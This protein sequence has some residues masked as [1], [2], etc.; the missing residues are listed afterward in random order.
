VLFG[1][2]QDPKEP[3]NSPVKRIMKLLPADGVGAYLAGKQLALSAGILEI[4]AVVGLALCLF[5]R[6]VGTQTKGGSKGQIVSTGCVGLSYI[7]WLGTIGDRLPLFGWL[8]PQ[9][10]TLAMIVLGV[11]V[12]YFYKGDDLADG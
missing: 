5:L 3:D 4:W 2:G 9:I 1:A 6:Y 8:S 12:P 7:A 11:V 10:A